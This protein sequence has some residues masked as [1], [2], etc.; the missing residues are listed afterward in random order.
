MRTFLSLIA[1]LSLGMSAL[2]G[3]TAGLRVGAASTELMAEDTMVIAGGIGPWYAHDQEGELRATALVVEK[4]GGA[5]VAIV[6]CDVLAIP[7]ELAD[8][9]AA[10]IEET[11][12]IPAANVLIHATH[13]H[14]APSTVHVH[15]Y[16]REGSFCERLRQ[17]IVQSVIDAKDNL[18][19]TTFSFKLGTESTVGINS[20]LLLGDGTIYWVGPRDDAVRPTGPFDP[21]LPVLLFRDGDG[22]LQA[23]L[24]GHSSHTIGSLKPGVRSPAFYGMVAQT[25]EGELGGKIAF[26]EGAS[27]STH[28]ADMKPTEAFDRIKKAV[29]D[30]TAQAEVQE[31]H[32]VASLKRPLAFKVRT[33]DEAAEDRAVS[34]YCKKR[35]GPNA[36]GVIQVFRQMREELAPQQGKERTTWVHTI[37]IGDVAIV[38]VPSEVFTKLGIDIKS[39]SPFKHTVIA[40]LSNDW[41]GYTPD[42]EAFALGGYQTWTGLHSYAEPG[43]GERIVDQAVAMLEEVARR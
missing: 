8:A 42:Q 2:T 24:Y 33:F 40:E 26:L 13:T 11:C 30:A 18:A 21:D 32:R 17:G 43:T 15:E 1:G 28:V 22:S 41:I 14:H 36:D 10:D 16:D 19:E 5:P 35:I 7:R 27:G 29:L 4:E 23:M 6:S 3:A 34:D 37:A 38:G 31:V 12:D 9:A 25:L 39:R 20:R